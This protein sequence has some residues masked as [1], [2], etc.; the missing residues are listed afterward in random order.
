M[1]PNN[2]SKVILGD[3]EKTIL[4]IKKQTILVI[5]I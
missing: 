3:F 2:N 1:K 4:K 5:K